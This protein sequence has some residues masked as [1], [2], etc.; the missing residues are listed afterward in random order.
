MP[1][2]RTIP[3]TC[4]QCGN[5]FLVSGYIWRLR[6][7]RYCGRDCYMRSRKQPVKARF[8]DFVDRASDD[9]CWHWLGAT[10]GNGY[11]VIRSN[12][13][14]MTY[15]HRL[16]YVI[17][18]GKI[19]NGHHVLHHCDNPPCVNPKHLFVGTHLDNVRDMHAKGRKNQSFPLT[20]R[21]SRKHD[22]CL[23]CGT[24]D[25][26]HHG[27]GRCRPCYRKHQRQAL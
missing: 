6:R 17:F 27:L 26:R 9:E 23:D 22:R 25:R 14:R 19:P 5:S 10:A 24:T 18:H 12:T 13:G 11:G 16:S 15:A 3:L 4:R 7:P 2:K 8:L 20:D 1:H 21:W